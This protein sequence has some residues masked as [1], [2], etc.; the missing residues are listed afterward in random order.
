M[1]NNTKIIRVTVKRPFQ[2]DVKRF[3]APYI[4]ESVCP[5]C[6]TKC[7]LDFSGPDYLSYPSVGAPFVQHFYHE[8]PD[9]R[10]HEWP[11]TIKIDITMEL[12]P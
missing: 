2:L 3:Y 1:D 12:V 9:G 4:L 5:R 8:C 11:V 6:A 10:E 7:R